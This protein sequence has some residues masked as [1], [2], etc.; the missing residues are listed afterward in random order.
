MIR[1]STRILDATIAEA[2]KTTV[3]NLPDALK[4]ELMPDLDP[5]NPIQALIAQALQ[6]RLNP[7]LTA[8]VTTVRGDD[9]K[10]T[11]DTSS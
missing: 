11:T 10:F 9:G 1:E 2:I 4:T 7:P 5:P 3:E 8:T 6:S